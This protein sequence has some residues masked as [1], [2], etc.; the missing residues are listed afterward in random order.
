METLTPNWKKEG[1]NENEFLDEIDEL[2]YRTRIYSLDIDKLDILSYVKEEG[3]YIYYHVVN[4]E[5]I[6]E[7]QGSFKQQ[8]KRCIRTSFKYL[9]PDF[10]ENGLILRQTKE[11]KKDWI[12]LTRKSLEDLIPI[13]LNMVPALGNLGRAICLMA[14]LMETDTPKKLLVRKSNQVIKAFVAVGRTYRLGDGQSAFFEEAL[15]K[16]RE[17]R[18]DFAF[19]KYSINNDLSQMWLELPLTDKF[20]TGICFST[21]ETQVYSGYSIKSYIKIGETYH[22]VETEAFEHRARTNKLFDNLPT[23]VNTLISLTSEILERWNDKLEEEILLPLIE[24]LI[25][26]NPKH[27]GYPKAELHKILATYAIPSDSKECSFGEQIHLFLSIPSKI[28]CYRTRS[29]QFENLTLD[30]LKDYLNKEVV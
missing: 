22:T 27:G 9:I 30:C 26:K 1:T 3:E 25:E 13:N 18:E 2:T 29:D 16:A 4:K 12:S 24:K 8:L 23:M 19:K 6:K 17:I 20:Q 10:K 7:Q 11:D 5:S 15:E 21:S 14:S 28:P